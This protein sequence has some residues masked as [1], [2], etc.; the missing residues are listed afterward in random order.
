LDVTIQAQI[1]ELLKELKNRLNTSIIMITHDLG[2]VAEVA[3]Y[4]LVMY[5]GEVV[6]YCDVKTLYKKPLHPYT[7]G[8]LNSLPKIE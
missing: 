5:A 4:V 2:V 8:L 3:D 7:Q 1:L 6:E